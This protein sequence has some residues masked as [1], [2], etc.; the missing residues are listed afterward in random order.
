MSDSAGFYAYRCYPASTELA[1]VVTKDGRPAVRCYLSFVVAAAREG[2]TVSRLQLRV[3][4]ARRWRPNRVFASHGDPYEIS[5]GDPDAPTTQSAALL[6]RT[7]KPVDLD[8]SDAEG[9]IYDHRE[10]VFLD[11]DGKV[12]TAAQILEQMYT[13]HCRTLRVAF[14]IRWNCGSAARW[15][16][17]QTVWKGQDSAM[18]VLLTFYDVEIVAD[19]KERR[20][21]FFY[22]YKPDD[23]RRVTENPG[24]RSNFFGFQTS[25]KSFLTNLTVVVGGCL[26]LY[27]AAP[28]D[29]LLRVVYD[30]TALTT[31]ALIFAFLVADTAGPWLLIRVIGVLSR[32][33]D[34]V[35][36]VIRKVSA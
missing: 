7:R 35:L 15:A 19:K 5:S 25:R 4:L 22:K 20:P 34:A 3:W 24:E 13:R 14:R 23:F 36:F 29:G 33:R 21:S 9:Y 17:R 2:S 11:G 31:A 27:R 26:L 16:I 32:L 28:H 18:W 1:K 6:A 12:V 30:N 8:S 10:D